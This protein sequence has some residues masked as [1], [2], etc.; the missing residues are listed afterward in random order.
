MLF[1]KHIYIYLYILYERS[2]SLFTIQLDFISY[3]GFLFLLL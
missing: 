2:K 3:V 1:D